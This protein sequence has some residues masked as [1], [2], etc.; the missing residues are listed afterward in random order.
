MLQRVIGARIVVSVG[1]LGYFVAITRALG[2]SRTTEQ[3][4][5]S[6]SA[7]DE[8]MDSLRGRFKIRLFAHSRHSIVV[9]DR[10][11]TLLPCTVRVIRALGGT[12]AIVGRVRSKNRNGV[13]LNYSIA[14]L[15]F[16]A[17]YVTSFTRGCPKVAVSIQRLSRTSHALTVA[18]NRC[19]FYF[20][21]ESVIPRD[22]NVRS[23]VARGR[24]LSIMATGGSGFD[25]EGD[26]GLSRLTS[27]DVL[28]LS[29]S[30]TPVM[31]VRVVSLFHAFRVAPGVRGS[32]SS[33]ISVCISSSSKVNIS[34]VPASITTCASSRCASSCLVSST[35]ADVTCIVT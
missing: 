11:G 24:A 15:S 14:S 17:G 29:R 26:I 34:I 13:A 33:L 18:N 25:K 23:V 10:N 32:F 30:I 19:S 4:C 31:C 27:R 20:V 7:I 1:R 5:I 6:R 35:S 12:G 8:C 21:P 9:A 2:F 28:M 3:G 16:P 22:S